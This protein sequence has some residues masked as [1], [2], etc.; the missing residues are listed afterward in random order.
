MGVTFT[1]EGV[2][3]HPLPNK[4]AVHPVSI[5]IFLWSKFLALTNMNKL[6]A[7]VVPVL[8]WAKIPHEKTN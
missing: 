1:A 4:I 6:T 5:S 7:N 2:E 3:S 8:N